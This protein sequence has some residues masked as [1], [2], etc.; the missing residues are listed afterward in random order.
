MLLAQ[1][2]H[3]VATTDAQTQGKEELWNGYQSTC[4]I[5]YF[6][7]AFLHNKINIIVNSCK[8]LVPA[9]L[10]TVL[11][12]SHKGDPSD[13]AQERPPRC[14]RF[15]QQVSKKAHLAQLL[16]KFYLT[17]SFPAVRFIC[18]EIREELLWTM[19]LSSEIGHSTQT[20]RYIA[21]PWYITHHPYSDPWL[22]LWKKK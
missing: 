18:L 13:F 1:S 6:V 19:S 14:Q 16:Y 12:L 9:Q 21:V 17:S 10:Q 22:L 2:G 20:V 8:F 15:R 5:F 3:S 11:C 4:R 7:G